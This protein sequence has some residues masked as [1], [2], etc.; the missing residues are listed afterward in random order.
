VQKILGVKESQKCKDSNLKMSISK[1]NRQGMVEI[2]FSEVM[3]DESV[4]FVLNRIN[5]ESLRV[6]VVQ[7]ETKKLLEMKWK[8]VSFEQDKLILS[9]NFTNPLEVSSQAQYP[10]KVVI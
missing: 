6:E 2:S 3:F 9:L 7:A 5:N 8:P 4:G 1:I 10:D